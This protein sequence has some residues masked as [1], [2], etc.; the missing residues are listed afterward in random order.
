MSKA[1]LEGV[2][3]LSSKRAT[4]NR[5]RLKLI[6]TTGVSCQPK[7]IGQSRFC[8]ASLSSGALN[9]WIWWSQEFVKRVNSA[10]RLSVAPAAPLEVFTTRVVHCVISG[11]RLS[12][13][14]S[15]CFLASIGHHLY[16]LLSAGMAITAHFSRRLDANQWCNECPQ[17]C[18]GC[19]DEQSHMKP[20]LAA[21][22]WRLL[23]LDPMVEIAVI[24]V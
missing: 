16:P 7:L 14:P 10:A 13:A 2:G 9:K 17:Q 5:T 8:H 24:S 11:V 4:S 18:S 19:G 23:H 15:W 20:L 21:L 3:S 12:V 1:H 6:A 22:Q